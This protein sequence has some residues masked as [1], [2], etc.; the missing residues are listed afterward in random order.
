M[1]NISIKY[2]IKPDY[3]LGIVYYLVCEDRSRNVTKALVKSTLK[4]F[5]TLYGVLK[6]KSL[7]Q[8]ETEIIQNR[9]KAEYICRQLYPDIF[10]KVD[11]EQS[12]NYIKSYE[13]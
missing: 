3:L 8:P 11:K 4:D 2:V 7:Y 13:V 9:I 5:L 1:K 10:R 12:I 6:V